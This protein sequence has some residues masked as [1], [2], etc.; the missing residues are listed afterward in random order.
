MYS[1]RV[2]NGRRN[3]KFIKSLVFEKLLTPGNIGNILKEIVYFFR[4]PYSKTPSDS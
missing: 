2:A 1:H 4:K 3:R